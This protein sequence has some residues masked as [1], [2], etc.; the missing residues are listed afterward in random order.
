MAMRRSYLIVLAFM[1]LQLQPVIGAETTHDHSSIGVLQEGSIMSDRAEVA[2]PVLQQKNAGI[3]T[4]FVKRERLV[5][6][7]RTVG[8][9]ATDQ[10]REAHIHTRLNGW[11]EKIH[12]DYVGKVVTKGAPLFDLYSPDLVS[13]QEEY[14]AAKRQGQ[15]AAEVAEAALTRLRLWGVP[16]Q[17]LEALRSAKMAKKALTFYA[18]VSGVV[19]RKAAIMGAYVTPDTELYYLADIDRVWLL[20]TL[21]EADVALIKPGDKVTL[22]LPYAPGKFY[23][24]FISYVYPEIDVQT[25]TAKARVEIANEDQF[26]RPGMFANAEIEKTLTEQIV[27]SEDAVLDTGQRKIVFVKMGDQAFVPREVTVGQRVG[28]QLTILSG[29]KEGEAVVVSASFLIDAESRLQAALRKGKSAAGG[30]SGH[31]D[32]VD[33]KGKE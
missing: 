15:V 4:Q 24:G 25:R 10:T 23:V 3:Q 20:L 13:T 11:I 30:H 19:I 5:H 21:Y 29:L 17:E 7:I 9:I 28:E 27:V 12:V 31:G 14:L 16:E 18:P 8:S 32:G 22:S 26:L 2:I 1:A 33:K 6:K